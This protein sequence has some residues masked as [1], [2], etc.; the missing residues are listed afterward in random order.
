M[1]TDIR[2]LEWIDRKLEEPFTWHY[3]PTTGKTYEF[4]NQEQRNNILNWRNEVVERIMKSDKSQP[5]K[6]AHLG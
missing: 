3:S 1:E 4:Y 6:C 5:H 2:L